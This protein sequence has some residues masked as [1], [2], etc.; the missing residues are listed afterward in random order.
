MI[1]QDPVLALGLAGV[2][3][4]VFL[5][6]AL[7][8]LRVIWQGFYSSDTGEF[9]LVYFTR[10]VDPV[11]A[12]HL[13][14]TVR[15]TLVMGIG[16]ATGGTVVGFIFAYTLVRCNMPF[17]RTVHMLSLIHISEPTRPY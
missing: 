15:N 13:W 8:L 5:F 10:F 6:I 14:T 9:S 7:P 2:I 11:W 16:A 1:G 12:P 17:A 3:S 4:F